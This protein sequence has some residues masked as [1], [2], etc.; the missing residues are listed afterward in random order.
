MALP[1]FEIPVG[2]LNLPG[3]GPIP[4][5]PWATLVCAGFVIG[6]EI[7]RNR[8]IKLG[9][10]VRDIVDGA[11]VTVGSGFLWGHIFTVLTYEPGDMMLDGR[12]DLR[13]AIGAN[14]RLW[15]GFASTGGFLGAVIGA[16]V[17]YKVIRRRP[18]FRHADVI[19]FGF[20]F[21]W[22]LGRLGCA[23]VHDHVGK[24]TTLPFGMDFDHGYILN[25]WPW[26]LVPV[27]GD[28]A[29]WAQGIR[30]ELGLTEA[31]YVAVLCVIWAILGQ[32]DRPPGFFLA[33][34]A[35]AYAP[36][37]FFLEFL[38]NTDL[39]H[40]DTRYFGLTP[41]Q[42]GG[43]VMALAGGFLLY[44]LDW[45][46]FQPVELGKTEGIAP[47]PEDPLPRN[48]W[49]GLGAWF[50]GYVLLL[51]MDLK[52][53]LLLRLVG[54]SGV[55]ALLKIDPYV[56]PWLGLLCFFGGFAAFLYFAWTRPVP[57]AAPAPEAAP[58]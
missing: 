21:G 50:L 25:D 10:D 24:I 12:F 4:L 39:S 30:W 44:K 20:P 38:R 26:N 29:P 27:A 16:V 54:Q 9:L 58:K 34:F 5:D 1:Y 8:A 51:L 40:P 46:G 15:E 52:Y 3:Y 57:G 28:P 48:A 36:V 35:I 2:S 22:F 37:R 43:V 33:L 17:F 53:S 11:V 6:L 41:A 14:V 31:A 13:T 49:I 19:T 55:D 56:E 32:K 7:A 18:L 42:Y 23:S 47:P 45:K